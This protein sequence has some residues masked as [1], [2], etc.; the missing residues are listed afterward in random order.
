MVRQYVAYALSYRNIEE[1]MKERGISID[2]A[3]INRW[4]IKYA[5]LLE[6]AFGN[7]HKRPTNQNWQIDETYIKIRGR[8]DY[9]YHAIDKNVKT[10]DFMFS[11]TCDHQAASKFFGKAIGSNGLPSAVQL[12]INNLCCLF[13]AV[14][15]V[16]YLNNIVEQDHQHIKR[17]TKPILGFKS[18]TAANATLAGIELHHMLKK[19]Q[20]ALFSI[21]GIN[22]FLH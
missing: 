1:M 5:P 18:F 2:R 20:C 22:Y 7:K 12:L 15:Q 10:I 13:I 3:T 9:L 11:V 17:I 4:V 19:G 6:K 8:W 16:K 21:P 14:R